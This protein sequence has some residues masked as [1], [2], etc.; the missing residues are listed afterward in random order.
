VTASD[1]PPLQLMLDGN[2]AD[3]LL[4]DEILRNGLRDLL[5][6]RAAEVYVTHV[7]VDETLKTPDQA[8]RDR[9][10]LALLAIGARL[11]PTSAFVFGISRL[12]LAN[13]GTDAANLALSEFM[14]GN[15]DHLEDALIA[16]TARDREMHFATA[17][18]SRGRLF[19]HTPEFVVLSVPDLRDAVNARLV[20]ERRLDPR[21]RDLVDDLQRRVDRDRATASG[22][23]PTTPD[24]ESDLL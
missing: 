17:E 19:R 7:A 15:Q 12:D 9:L 22:A 8:R 3:V 18:K 23:T 1:E 14:E 16:T 21:Q 10:I 20:R 13:L 2:I 6:I 5:D 11:V 24:A 4:D